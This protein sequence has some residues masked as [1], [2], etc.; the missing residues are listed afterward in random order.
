MKSMPKIAESEWEVMKV[1]WT[2]SPLSANQVVDALADTKHWKPKTIKTLLN[3]LVQKKALGFKKDGRAYQYFPLVDEQQCVRTESRSFL[4]RVY[5][6]ATIPM[7]AAFLE[8]E[9]LS[10]EEIADLKRIL[11]QKGEA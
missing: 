7:L 8:N 5:G 6:G 3:R 2:Q 9:E 11:D 1:L 4:E 10:P